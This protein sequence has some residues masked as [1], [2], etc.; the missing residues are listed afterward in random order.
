VGFA[1]ALLVRLRKHNS[2]LEVR[3]LTV[4]YRAER[5]SPV[6]ALRE[7]SLAINA[8]EII[9]VLGESGSGKSTLALALSRLL[10]NAAQ[11][12]GGTIQFRDL[13][14]LA[15]SEAE[16]EDVRG[17]Q[18]SLLGQDPNQALNPVL[19]VGEQV[20]Q[21]VRAHNDI[22]TKQCRQQATEMMRRVG[23]GDARHYDAYPHQLSGGQ[24]QR[25]VISQALVCR[26]ALLI[27][28]EPTS[29]LDPIIEL[30][31]LDLL[32]RLVD[33][34]RTAV[35]FISHDPNIVER[36]THRTMV[37]YA[38]CIVESGR[39][40]DVFANPLHPYTAGLLRSRPTSNYPGKVPLVCIPGV[41]PDLSRCSIGC[42]FE[43]RCEKRMLECAKDDPEEFATLEDGHSVR[44]FKYSG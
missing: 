37:M 2:L 9:G 35:L 26:P 34:L 28:D 12:L 25:V 14:L 24:K 16:M 19:R 40:A 5:R 23:L 39:T 32:Q 41:P 11:V 21:V 42:S 4:Q 30:E 36:I 31:I 3:V 8:G 6:I 20:A 10:P 33:E 17:A 27:A 15:L 43:P 29:A 7:I 44:C 18:I 13:D 38:G 22:S 1:G